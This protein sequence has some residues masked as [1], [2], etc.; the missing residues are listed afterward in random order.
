MRRSWLVACLT[1]TVAAKHRPATV[2]DPVFVPGKCPASALSVAGV[3]TSWIR[4][5]TVT[6]PQNR[7]DPTAARLS[8][9][10]L[11]VVVY[12]APSAKEKTPLVFLAGGPGEPAIDVVRE[13]FLPSPVG[14]LTLRE[15]P[16]IAFNQRGFG[17]TTSGAAPILGTL[18][19]H[20]RATREES[21][22]TL[23][24]SARKI[25]ARLRA[26]GIQPQYFT[27]LHAVDDTRDVVRALGYEHMFLFA[28]SYGTKL[29]LQIMRLHPEMVEASILDGVAPPQSIDSF[30]P[31]LLDER[32]RAV[33]ARLIDDCEKSSPCS[34]EYRELRK[35]ASDLDRTDTPPVHIVVHLPS[36]GGWFD[37]DLRGRDLLSAVGAYAGTE[38][39]R[40]M[41]QVLE[42]LAH[43]DT[44]RRT[45][46]PE[47]VLHVVHETA[48][49]RTA[50]PNYPVIYH[51]VL[52]GDIPSGV[53]QAGGRAVCDALGVPFSGLDAINPVTSDIPTLMFS[54]AY[55]AQTPPDMAADAAR[56]LARSYRVLF[57]GIGHLAYA[58]PISASCV[59][60]IAHAFLFDPAHEPPDPCSKSLTP[61]FLPRSADLK[62]APR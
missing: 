32:R 11:S 35:L 52:C 62:L 56:T 50:G 15:R 46:S 59:A 54:S 4:C 28:T 24:D 10:V 3:D 55:D 38:F 61:S 5:G 1:A 18:A 8:P 34:S 33:A 53:L 49:A 14:Q 60:V 36:G 44:V 12:E 20:W 48:L 25:V 37:L 41:P 7:A 39:A 31:A 6:V 16:I 23:V 22:E 19:Y 17:D 43:G 29:A 58:R 21:I 27:T 2:T 40:A 57:P 9:V 13:V 26:K 51:I 45:M 42:E 47:L 30:D